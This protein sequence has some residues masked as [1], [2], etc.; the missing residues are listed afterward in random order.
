MCSDKWVCQPLEGFYELN[1]GKSAKRS[2]PASKQNPDADS[3]TGALQCQKHY[4]GPPTFEALGNPPV[5]GFA[6]VAVRAFP[7]LS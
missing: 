2:K 1:I 6:R 7:S 3:R 4:G 5:P